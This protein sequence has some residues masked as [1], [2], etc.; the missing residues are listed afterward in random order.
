MSSYSEFKSDVKGA[1]IG[2]FIVL[3]IGVVYQIT[4]L[5]AVGAISLVLI[6]LSRLIWGENKQRE[7]NI[8]GWAIA[9]VTFF[10][11]GM[12]CYGFYQH[13]YK[14]LYGPKSTQAEAHQFIEEHSTENS[15]ILNDQQKAYLN[16]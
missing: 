14:P 5:L 9:A 15:F 4:F 3:L 2:V 12:V 10:A 1:A 16:N 13:I 11:M 8:K 6:L 7:E